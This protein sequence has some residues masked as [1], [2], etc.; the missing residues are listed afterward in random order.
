MC[1]A[2]GVC[3][4]MPFYYGLDHYLLVADIPAVMQK[5]AVLFPSVALE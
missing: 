1:L 3:L 5:M 4:F 2:E